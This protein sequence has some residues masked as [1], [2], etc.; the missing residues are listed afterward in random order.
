MKYSLPAFLA[1][2]IALIATAPLARA[3]EAK[4]YLI[5]LNRPVTVGDKSH[6]TFKYEA[7]KQQR[8]SSG[9]KVVS[10]KKEVLKAEVAG[11]GE[12]LALTP[13]GRIQKFTFKLEKFVVQTDEGAPQEPF[14]AGAIISGELNE[15]GKAVYTSDGG[16]ITKSARTVIEKLLELKPD[17]KIESDDDKI[18][19]TLAPRAVGTEWKV[20]PADALATMPEDMPFKVAEKDLTGV[21]K[22]PAVKQVR[23]KDHG[24]F[25]AVI[26]IQPKEMDL[27][28]LKLNSMVIRAVMEKDV[29]LDPKAIVP[30]SKTVFS[31][32]MDADGN[33]PN[34]PV[35]LEMT[36]SETKTN[37]SKNLE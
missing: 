21:V 11:V 17:K 8:V 30:F 18:F 27:K 19:G 33:T 12:V 14:K 2:S 15:L 20:I 25:Q 24:V 35:H 28:G 9:E 36:A 13:H 3:D 31:S 23:G 26:T 34:G 29:P 22:F 4:S 5:K 10:D 16:E 32:T 1:V 37:E 7:A 6:E